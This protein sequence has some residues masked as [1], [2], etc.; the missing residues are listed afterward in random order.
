M[1]GAATIATVA[2]LLLLVATVSYAIGYYV[3]SG[4]TVEVRYFVWPKPCKLS[5][6]N[7]ST[8]Q[9]HP[10]MLVSGLAYR[11][12]FVNT[13]EP[14]R[15]PSPPYTE[16]N[17]SCDVVAGYGYYECS[18]VGYVYVPVGREM[19][20]ISGN[21]V[22]RYY[23]SGP[24]AGAAGTY[25]ILYGYKFSIFML[26]FAVPLASAAIAYALLK[27]SH[28]RFTHRSAEMLFLLCAVLA[29]A[30]TYCGGLSGLGTVPEEISQIKAYLLNMLYL[31]MIETS[32]IYAVTYFIYAKIARRLQITE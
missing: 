4:Y 29:L 10:V 8:L 12:I 13:T 21:E 6:A 14:L 32:A 9:E 22:T 23:Y 1:K 7:F 16:G 26:V 15:F 3:G 18:G 20:V 5:I 2:I 11:K 25:V 17:I 19:E 27:Y 28:G 31:A 24:A 30:L